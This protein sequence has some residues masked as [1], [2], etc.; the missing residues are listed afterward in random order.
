MERGLD[1]GTRMAE[2][3]AAALGRMNTT[4][5]E[6]GRQVD[7]LD[8]S[9]SRGFKRA[10][11]GVL[12]DG[13]SISD[14]LRTISKS[15]A[16][17]AYNAAVDPVVA[18]ASS[19]T[20][21][22]ISALFSGLLP[23]ADGASFSQGRVMPFATGGVVNA[24]TYFPMRGGQTGLMGEA[25][26][27]AIMPLSR[28]ADGR[29]GVRAAGGAQARPVSVVF[30]IKTP[31]VDGFSRSQSQIASRLGQVIAQAQRASV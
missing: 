6:T 15:V 10:L 26:P 21:G 14:G 24:P 19:A 20:A 4:F 9:L 28:G 7:A 5:S 18:P 1:Q 29:L 8:R 17:T 16:Q 27:E 2:G 11:D 22:A 30:N 31:D 23:F 25:G 12:L 3:F 13:K